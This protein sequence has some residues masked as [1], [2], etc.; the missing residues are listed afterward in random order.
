M[1]TLRKKFYVVFKGR[2]PGIYDNW[3]ACQL[4]VDGFSGN[5]HQSYSNFQDALMAW[6]IFIDNL[7]IHGEAVLHDDSEQVLSPNHVP[8]VLTPPPLVHDVP[9]SMQKK[10]SITNTRW[11]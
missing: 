6:Q 10:L 2:V 1:V 7:S 8:T 11:K 5:L 4:Q 9:M 3:P